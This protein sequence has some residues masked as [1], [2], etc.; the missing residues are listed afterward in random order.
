MVLRSSNLFSI[1]DIHQPKPKPPSLVPRALVRLRNALA[2]IGILRKSQVLLAN[3]RGTMLGAYEGRPIHF[4]ID[5]QNPVEPVQTGRF[6]SFTTRPISSST[7]LI[8]S[9]SFILRESPFFENSSFSIS[10]FMLV[11]FARL[12]SQALVTPSPSSYPLWSFFEH[13]RDVPAAPST[14]TRATNV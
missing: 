11:P 2:Q 4:R 9:L 6:L 7:W 10:L 5:G 1:I 13:N 12:P 8:S 3:D 14:W